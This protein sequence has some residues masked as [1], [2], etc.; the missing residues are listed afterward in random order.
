MEFTKEENDIFNEFT[1]KY[2]I[3]FSREG[4]KIKCLTKSLKDRDLIEEKKNFISRATSNNLQQIC[5]LQPTPKPEIFEKFLDQ[6]YKVEW[7]E[8]NSENFVYVYGEDYINNKI[9]IKNVEILLEGQKINLIPSKKYFTINIVLENGKIVDMGKLKNGKAII[10]D[11]NAKTC[12]P[13]FN[14]FE[15]SLLH[16][17]DYFLKKRLIVFTLEISSDNV[18]FAGIS[19]K[20]LKSSEIH[21]TYFLRKKK[22]LF[23]TD[24]GGNIAFGGEIFK[25]LYGYNE[26]YM[27][28]ETFDN[29]ILALNA[30]E[31]TVETELMADEV[32]KDSSELKDKY[33]P[34]LRGEYEFNNNVVSLKISKRNL[35]LALK[36]KKW[37][38][39]D[40]VDNKW[41]I[42]PEY[43]CFYCREGYVVAVKE[44]LQEI[45]TLEGKKIG[46]LNIKMPVFIKRIMGEYA[47]VESQEESIIISLK[48]YER[49]NKS[50]IKCINFFG[51]RYI[52]IKNTSSIPDIIDMNTLKYI[53]LQKHIFKEYEPD[54]I[55]IQ[56]MF[57]F[58]TDLQ[59]SIK[60]S[61]NENLLGTKVLYGSSNNIDYMLFWTDYKTIIMKV[62]K[63][64]YEF[65]SANLHWNLIVNKWILARK[66]KEEFFGIWN[67]EDL[68][69][70]PNSQPKIKNIVL[71][72]F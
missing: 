35:I 62:E 25:R 38:I 11:Y 13:Y 63:N 39:L 65:Y 52:L 31:H 44:D 12:N 28:G 57:D 30:K 1:K 71:E 18:E 15:I 17:G 47:I 34:S 59:I 32:S 60:D 5:I 64:K 3:I 53:I 54:N 16:L 23:A 10:Y 56:N 68:I 66:L 50:K 9:T 27:I 21:E 55:D 20:E 2:N 8:D 26:N 45:Y 69:N 29:R 67:I 37:G 19:G 72:L 22:I 49:V 4:G 14:C 41:T 6:S 7:K 46:Q 48:T 40:L 58:P 61:Y 24:F 43:D 70:E 36:D 51:G 33:P 42:L